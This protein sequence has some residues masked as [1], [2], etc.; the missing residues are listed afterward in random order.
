[1][2]RMPNIKIVS[3][4]VGNIGKYATFYFTRYP[5]HVCHFHWYIQVSHPMLPLSSLSS[6]LQKCLIVY[7]LWLD[8]AFQ[9]P[10]PTKRS[11]RGT[12]LVILE[13]IPM[14]LFFPIQC[15]IVYLLWLEQAFQMPPPTKRS[16]RGTNLV[17]LEAI[18]MILFFPIQCLI[19]YLLW[20]EQTFQ[21]PPP[22]TK[23]SP[24]GTSLVILEAIPMIL[25]FPIQ[26]PGICWPNHSHTGTAWSSSTLRL[27]VNV[28]LFITIYTLR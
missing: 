1:M 6:R 9:M 19:V 13:A 11:P 2:E 7:L 12:N 5:P 8:Q 18:P 26:W 27:Q 15:L 16:P 28:A 22:T 3:H 4:L 17:I 25:F 23:R 21:M 20:L 14:I 24:R 10:P